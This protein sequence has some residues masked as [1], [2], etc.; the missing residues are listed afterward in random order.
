MAHNPLISVCIPMFNASPFIRECIDSV[1]RQS[2]ADFELLIVDDGSTDD[3]RDI[4]LSYYDDRIRLIENKH[5]YIGSLNM[6]LREAKGKYIARMD[7]DDIMF[8][9]RLE[10]QF[11]YMEQNPQIDI[12]GAAMQCFGEYNDICTPC[13]VGEIGY[14]ELLEC[15]GLFHPTVF[16]RNDRIRSQSIFYRYKYIFAEDY[17]FWAE[18]LS[19]GLVLANIGDIVLNY[20]V[21]PTQVS[22]TK[23]E[24]QHEHSIM[25]RKAL[26]KSLFDFTESYLS[27]THLKEDNNA[28]L[29]AI[30]PFY[31]EG[32][33]LIRTLSSIRRTAGNKIKI[34]IVDDKSDDGFDYKLMSS[35]YDVAYISNPIRLGPAMSK[36]KGVQCCTTPNFILLDAHMRFYQ[37][38][39]VDTI[40]AE[41]S[42]NPNQ[43]LCCQ[44]KTL[45]IVDGEVKE[46]DVATTYGAYI[47]FGINN[48]T[49][50]AIWNT[51]PK[52]RPLQSGHIP[53]ILGAT[54]A[55]S[56]KYWN[57]LR[58]F[59]GLL[60]YGCEEPLIS[61]K[62]WLQ[63]GK[64]RFLQNISVGHVYKEYSTVSLMNAKYTYN[65]LYI[66]YLL[67]PTS[68]R[69]KVEAVLRIKGGTHYRMAKDIL[70]ATIDFQKNEK[71]K[72]LDILSKNDFDYIK[73]INYVVHPSD[74]I[75]LDVMLYQLPDILKFCEGKVC[76]VKD[77]SLYH[78][79]VGFSILFFLFARHTGKPKWSQ[80]ARFL[81]GEVKNSIVLVKDPKISLSEGIAG[82]GW[83][84]LYLVDNEFI[85]Y[86][87]V[88]GVLCRIDSQLAS[89][90]PKR[91][92]DHTLETGVTGLAAYCSAR[93]GFNKRHHVPSVFP[94]D[95]IDE[96]I[97]ASQY[98]CQ[99]TGNSTNVIH[100]SQ[101][102]QSSL[103]KDPN[104]AN[105]TIDFNDIIELPTSLIKNQDYWEANLKYGCLG[106]AINLLITK[107]K[108]NENK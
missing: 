37:V 65:F 93:I 61:L 15:C 64:C 105:L 45:R 33:E 70:E 16:M 30:I 60:C 3:S 69:C 97:E 72:L 52:I 103:L 22:A 35:K 90:S 48:Y 107:Y 63:G 50:I 88:S 100:L 58:G 32:D 94:D 40:I 47:Y 75:N 42:D 10:V 23:R 76:H 24:T 82:V 13:R 68:L 2:F 38:D 12:L 66:A 17:A 19:K 62:A 56:K 53:C 34:I 43:I 46:E 78:G 4:V 95:F 29:T 31:N 14:M 96:L 26:A 18:A 89:I 101:N 67:F 92:K 59:R 54:Y 55:S 28:L 21:S 83:G 74:E 106:Y 73:T 87:E 91:M 98:E 25:V 7:A 27:T 51:N 1:L 71:K 104:W 5:D 77:I 57:K 99:N 8:V 41:L 102:L 86:Q 20:R 84:L 81:I 9:N 85:T 39:W 36:E 79:I 6:L 80:K 49:P 108:I 11:N 44:T